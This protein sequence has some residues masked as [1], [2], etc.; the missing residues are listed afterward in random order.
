MIIKNKLMGKVKIQKDNSKWLGIGIGDN[1]D[2]I[3]I[4]EI[5]PPETK[6]AYEVFEFV[7]NNI[8]RGTVILEA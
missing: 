5:A 2:V 1:G 8:S 7:K 4:V 6:T 3:G